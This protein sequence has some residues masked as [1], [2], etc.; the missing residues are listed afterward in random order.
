MVPAEALAI[1]RARQINKDGYAHQLRDIKTPEAADKQL[2]H[3]HSFIGALKTKN[4]QTS[5]PS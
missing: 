1:A 2:Q 3:S 5:E 4:Q